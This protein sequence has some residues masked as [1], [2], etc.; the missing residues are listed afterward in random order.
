MKRFS[1]LISF[2]IALVS[3]GFAQSKKI[4]DDIYVTPNDAGMVKEVQTAKKTV[5]E[6]PAYKN[7]AREIIF[8]DRNGKRTTAVTDTVYV[9]DDTV[10]DS[11][12]TVDTVETEGEYLRGFKG[13]QQDLEYAERIRRF[14]NP[15]YTITIADPGYNDIYFLDENDWNVYVDGIYATITPTWTNPYWF[16]YQYFPYGYSSWGWRNSLYSSFGWGYYDPW[17]SPWSSWY[18]GYGYGWGGYYDWGYPYYGGI[19]AGVI[20]IMVAIMVMVAWV[21]RILVTGIIPAIITIPVRTDA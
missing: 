11:I 19:M 6:K 7:G 2:L 21:I 4:I 17:Y 20:R 15:R 14:H 13:S 3:S 5:R 18:G 1:L 16:N 12:E 10:N 9:M 8:I